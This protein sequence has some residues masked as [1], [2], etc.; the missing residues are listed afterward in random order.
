[1]KNTY[2][3]IVAFTLLLLGTACGKCTQCLKSNEP[4]LT[5]CES[6]FT[7]KDDYQNQIAALKA[8][9]YTCS[10]K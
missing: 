5:Y 6:D 3:I 7:T 10:E 2:S 8:L 9:G 1:M 4:N